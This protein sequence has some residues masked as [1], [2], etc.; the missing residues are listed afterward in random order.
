MEIP[1]F[2][3]FE[4][5]DQDVTHWRNLLAGLC[6]GKQGAWLESQFSYFGPEAE[7][8]ISNLMDS[9]EAEHG[10][11]FFE[12]LEQQG[13]QFRIMMIG[14]YGVIDCLPKMEAIFGLCR[15][16]KLGLRPEMEE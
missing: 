13:N 5:P 2:I 6:G 9:C 16:Q 7:A 3:R 15:V 4:V 14:G 11:V 1:V 10:S 8:A 12:G